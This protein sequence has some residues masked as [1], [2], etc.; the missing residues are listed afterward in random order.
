VNHDWNGEI[1][2]QVASVCRVL[3]EEAD[4]ELALQSALECVVALCAGDAAALHIPT[5]DQAARKQILRTAGPGEIPPASLEQ[6]LRTGR[7]IAPSGLD[8]LSDREDA[9]NGFDPICVL[10]LRSQRMN[11]GALAVRMSVG[12]RMDARTWDALK[13]IARFVSMRLAIENDASLAAGLRAQ[14]ERAHELDRIARTR[15]ATRLSGGSD[16]GPYSEIIGC[17]ESVLKLLA[18]MDRLADG[19]QIVLIVGE[20]G[21][22]VLLTTTDRRN[23]L[24]IA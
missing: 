14:Q 9:S 19:P 12:T 11:L 17:S 22:G 7:S 21:T 24:E 13:V 6:V 3:D 1:T 4:T 2:S 15:R 20:S 23:G 18:K 8:D 16:A 10:A 5:V